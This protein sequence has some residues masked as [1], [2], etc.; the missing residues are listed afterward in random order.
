[1]L[2]VQSVIVYRIEHREYIN[3]H[4]NHFDGPYNRRYALFCEETTT[5]C[6]AYRY[7]ASG[8]TSATNMYSV[9]YRW[10]VCGDCSVHALKRCTGMTTLFANTMYRQNLSSSHRAVSNCRFS[11]RLAVSSKLMKL[12]TKFLPLLIAAQSG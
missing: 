9:V 10:H 2:S 6:K 3:P 5:Q 8:L 4:S 1:M 7:R 11:E 12:S